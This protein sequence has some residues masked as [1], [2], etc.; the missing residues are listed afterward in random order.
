MLLLSVCSLTCCRPTAP[1]TRLS[2]HQQ[3][4]RVAAAAKR[5]SRNDDDSELDAAATPA[6]DAGV[7][8]CYAS[9]YRGQ[10]GVSGDMFAG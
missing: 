9:V 3:R 10:G 2:H 6:A 5:A 1:V 4:R 8:L 7:F